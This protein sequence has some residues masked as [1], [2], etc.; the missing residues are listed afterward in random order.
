MDLVLVGFDLKAQ[1]V[2]EWLQHVHTQNVEAL[3]FLVS[4]YEVIRVSRMEKVREGSAFAGTTIVVSFPLPSKL[5]TVAHSMCI[6]L[7]VPLL[8]RPKLR[9]SGSD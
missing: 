5:G 9:Y 6:T 1:E 2:Q 8:N 4:L 7:M 3:A